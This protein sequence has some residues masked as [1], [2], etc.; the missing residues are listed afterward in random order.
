MTLLA[1][2]YLDGAT[3][4][5]TLRVFDAGAG[6]T[7]FTSPPF[8]DAQLGSPYSSHCAVSA[9]EDY[10]SVSSGYDSR[11]YKTA[12]WSFVS[13]SGVYSI[14][15]SPDG[16]VYADG[17][18]VDLDTGV[19][20]PLGFSP[21][22]NGSR[23]VSASG[24]L[25][26]GRANYP[27]TNIVAY[28][29]SSLTPDALGPAISGL[30]NLTQDVFVRFSQDGRFLALSHKD[31]GGSNRITLL[32]ADSAALLYAGARGGGITLEFSTSGD[33]LYVDDGRIDTTT[34]SVAA[35]TVPM[36]YTAYGPMPV[37]LSEQDLCVIPAEYV[38][39]SANDTGYAISTQA[40]TNPAWYDLPSR[41]IYAATNR[42]TPPEELPFWTRRVSTYELLD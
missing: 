21:A 32:D 39:L 25:M 22:W 41:A 42:G 10:V 35:W 18:E 11:I 28:D 1:A 34:F 7:L 13:V 9:D 16:R 26:V 15:F 14:V 17:G 12:D 8:G 27:N 3:N 37:I 5:P 23:E 30:V 2:V 6:A 24:H 33:Y 19:V 40:Q 36:P 20:T 38:A 31:G 29:L 4:K